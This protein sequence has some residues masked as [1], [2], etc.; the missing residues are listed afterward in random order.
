MPSEEDIG[1][2]LAA[3]RQGGPPVPLDLD[4]DLAD[5]ASAERVQAHAVAAYGDRVVGWKIGCTSAEAQRMMRCDRPFFGPLF[6][7]NVYPSGATLA[8][9]DKVRFAECEFAFRM[10]RAFPAVGEAATLENLLAA[11][12]TCHPAIEIVGRRTVG[13]SLPSIRSGIAD[14]GLNVAFFHG[15][16]IPRWREVDLI[17]APVIGKV[18]GVAVKEGVG[19]NALGDPRRA[20]LWLATALQA[21]GRRLEAGDWISTGTCL[22]VL[23][24]RRGARISGDYGPLGGVEMSFAA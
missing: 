1:A 19:G 11:V 7:A 8:M 15:P 6:E 2:R 17:A 24:V 16:A 12:E 14:F 21:R 20:L 23:P 22:N 4:A 5:L 9:T 18:D 3:A 10:R 13:E